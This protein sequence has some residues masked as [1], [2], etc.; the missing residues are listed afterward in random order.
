M[1]AA[2]LCAQQYPDRNVHQE[3]VESRVNDP[4]SSVATTGNV[5]SANSRRAHDAAVYAPE[6]NV[7]DEARKQYQDGVD[8]L[9]KDDLRAAEQDFRKAVELFPK[10]SSAYNALGVV[11]RKEGHEDT[12]GAALDRALELNPNNAEAEKNRAAIYLQAGK[13]E[14]AEK[15]QRRAT[16]LQPHEAAGFV[17]LAYLELALKRYD[18]AL[19]ASKDAQEKNWKKYPII[20]MIRA[21]SFEMKDERGEAIREYKAYLKSKPDETHAKMARE[22]IERLR[23]K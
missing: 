5:A 2:A 19:Q 16:A 7:P 20:R 6:L 22:S 4:W 23:K 15:L 9:K 13:L 10:Y 14:D 21:R 1:V 18:A 11:L 12:A 8:A 3:T 17:T